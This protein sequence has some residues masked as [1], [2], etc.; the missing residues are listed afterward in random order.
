MSHE[1]IL[2]PTCKIQGRVKCK[3]HAMSLECPM[4]VV[5]CVPDVQG[6]GKGDMQDSQYNYVSRILQIQQE[7]VQWFIGVYK[8]T[9]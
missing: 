1:C 4:N 7:K 8:E 9:K 2:H 5:S 3:T 6:L